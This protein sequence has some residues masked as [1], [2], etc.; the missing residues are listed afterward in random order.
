MVRQGLITK[1]EALLRVE[2]DQLNQVLPQKRLSARK[3]GRIPEFQGIL[4]GWMPA[5]RRM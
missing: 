1:E 3:Q 2:P 4:V 5:G